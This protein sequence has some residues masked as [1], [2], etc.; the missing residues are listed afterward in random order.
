M[1]RIERKVKLEK[2][3][4]LMILAESNPK[5]FSLMQGIVPNQY[6]VLKLEN[7]PLFQ[8]WSKFENQN[9]EK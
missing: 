1:Q 6:S 4:V 2:L 8:A 3:L 9:R 7:R 5:P